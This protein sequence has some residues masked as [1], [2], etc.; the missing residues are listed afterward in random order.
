M[1]D[2]ADRVRLRIRQ[3]LQSRTMRQR[4]LA[5]QLG[6]SP[7]RLSKILTAQTSLTVDDLA[8]LCQALGLSLVDVLRDRELEFCAEL[9]RSELRCLERIR[10]QP[11]TIEALLVLLEG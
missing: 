4:T 5:E 3:E 8:A 7:T 1:A 6:W 9:T 2:I 11:R 10:Q